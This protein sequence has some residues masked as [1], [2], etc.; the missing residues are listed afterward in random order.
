MQQRNQHWNEF[1]EAIM[2]GINDRTKEIKKKQEQKLDER[3]QVLP[4]QPGTKVMAINKT[5]SS[6]WDPQFEGPYEV[7][8]QHRGG[9]YTLKDATGEIVP[10]RRTI[11]MLK[12]IG[13][14]KSESK[15]AVPS[16]GVVKKEEESNLEEKSR[17][18]VRLQ[19]KRDSEVKSKAS[20]IER[21]EKNQGVHL[22][23]DRIIDHR[24]RK[25]IIEYLVKWK[26]YQEEENQW[27]TVEDF[28][29]LQPIR[30]Y[31][32]EKQ[33]KERFAKI[34]SKKTK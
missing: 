12:P 32:K 18:S 11:D 15:T 8:K 14:H 6:K 29:G 10:R 33:L 25:G 21:S 22:E 13:D 31:W 1:K 9:A 2:P 23:I 5:R 16:G 7:V 34:N 3:K 27:R 4:L 17:R 19:K 30:N 26:N 20:E 28:D 24:M